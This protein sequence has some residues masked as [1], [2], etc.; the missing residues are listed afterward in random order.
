MKIG[1]R[2]EQSST[3][4]TLVTGLLVIV[5]FCGI[6]FKYYNMLY[7]EK[8]AGIVKDVEMTAKESANLF[9]KYLSTNIDLINFTAYTLNEMI[10][11]GYSDEEIQSYLVHQS[12]AIKNSV[13]RNSTGLY[14]YINGK[15]MSGTNWEPPEG[16]D[17]TRRPWYTKPMENKGKLT[18]LEPYLDVQS[19]NM[20]LALGKTLSDGESVISVDVSIDAIQSLTEKVIR[21]KDLDME[22]VLTGDGI[23]VA[24]SNHFEIGKDY[25]DDTSS[26]GGIIARH[27]KEEGDSYFEVE[28]GGSYFIVYAA[29]FEADW[30]FV[31]VHDATEAFGSLRRMLWATIASVIATVLIIGLIL[32]ISRRRSVIAEKAVAANEAKSSFLS[33]MSHEIRTPINAMLGMNEMILRE[34]RDAKILE[35]SEGIKMAGHTLLGLVNNVLDFSRIESGKLEIIRSNYDLSS[36]L[37][38]LVSLIAPMADQKGLELK[39][40]FDSGI[41][42]F[43]CGDE[44]RLKQVIANILTNAVKYTNNGSI[45]FGVGYERDAQEDDS[46]I[47]KVSVRDT[48]IGI[49]EEDIGQLFS[50]F[51]RIE[52]RR[53]RNIEGTGLGMNI[54]LRLLEMMGS[55]LKVDSVYGSG[56]VFS[57]ELKQKVVK[58]DK[59]GD[60]Q[61]EYRKALEESAV[62]KER[63]AAP[64]AEILIVDDNPMNHVVFKGLLKQ[65]EI[66]IQTADSGAE[67]LEYASA[68][69]FDILFFD[70]MM[71][72]MDGIET[73]EKLREM[74]DGPNILTPVICLTANAISGARE[75][76]LA[77]G[78]DDYLTKP[79]DPEELENLIIKYLPVEK[80]EKREE[81]G[82]EESADISGTGL[83]EELR[84]L[85]GQDVIDVRAGLENSKYI[86]S[87]LQLI[88]LFYLS[89]EERTEELAR[90]CEEGDVKNYTIRVHGLKSS[91]RIIGANDLGEKALL[92]EEAGKNSD[93]EYIKENQEAFF[94]AYRIVRDTLEPVFESRDDA[95]AGN[96]HN[97]SK[98][99]ADSERMADVYDRLR[100]AADDMDIDLLQNI[101]EEMNGYRVPEEDEE[102]WKSI[103]AA[104]EQFD[105]DQ[106]LRLTEDGKTE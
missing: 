68:H 62:Y 10:S 64:E 49:K 83:P 33:N 23:V 57:F 13:F 52:E 50:E 71:P 1:E 91:A 22:M 60:F 78:F 56:S 69:K 40:D 63:F 88:R 19:G 92:L 81:T 20:M 44:V 96:K 102:K 3:R 46:I 48:G 101:I 43:L 74:K 94:E 75:K 41:P 67:G 72:G 38:D 93:I 2:L 80:I 11:A 100:A 25:S 36:V 104:A 9:E 85:E 45:V 26:L 59:L 14:A 87:Y 42:K 84:A 30:H 6:I 53:N 15:F 39:L 105:Y 77:A 98:K 27:L 61:T 35:Y 31:S 65:T 18:I 103:R 34:S 55:T 37:N 29:P 58:E 95:G 21:H 24:H 70:H 4:R 86:D 28:N 89:Y 47:L 12:T 90:Y 66:K 16:Y 54:T 97:D 73:L 51:E 32:G 5:F 106:I 79:I 99:Y 82:T 17:A 7:A 76:Y 8:R